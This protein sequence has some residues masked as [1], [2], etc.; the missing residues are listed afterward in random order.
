MGHLTTEFSLDVGHLNG[1]FG[2]GVG[3]LT[4]SKLKSSN[5][6]GV[7]RVGGGCASFE[8]IGTLPYGKVSLT[9]QE[10]SCRFS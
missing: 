10:A 8:L 6:R 3:N 9:F 4:T 2:P 7:A 1:V 5:A